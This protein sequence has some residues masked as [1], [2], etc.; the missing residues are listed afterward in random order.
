MH[1]NRSDHSL[2]DKTAGQILNN[3]IQAVRLG[4]NF[5]FNIGPNAQGHV[6]DRDRSALDRIGQWLSKHGEAVYGTR[7][8]GIYPVANQGP[9][10]HYG[11]FTCRGNT[12]YFIIFYYPGDYVILSQ[13]GPRVLS[14]E[15]MTTG[16]RL[17][18][19]P[20]SNSRWK[21]SGLPKSPP[22]DLAPVIK[23]EFES[24]PHLLEFTDAK[25]LDGKYDRANP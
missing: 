21:L 25:W 3:L 16:Q 15:L 5:L 13:I 11:M 7:P 14:A 20:L 2:A 8:E 1:C 4:G 10:Y 19:E 17:T 22:A 6:A 24:P 12:A 23:I 18:V 9:C